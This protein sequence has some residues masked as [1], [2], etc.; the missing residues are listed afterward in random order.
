MVLDLC[1]SSLCRITVNCHANVAMSTTRNFSHSSSGVWE[2]K[3]QT[4]AFHVL[5]HHVFHIS[6][7]IL[8]IVETCSFSDLSAHIWTEKVFGLWQCPACHCKLEPLADTFV[9][10]SS[11]KIAFETSYVCIEILC[12]PSVKLSHHVISSIV[13][14]SPQPLKRGADTLG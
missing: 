2:E 14:S 10:K 11:K 9:S 12:K 13:C 8:W 7:R 5:S 1:V 4:T 6:L 3:T